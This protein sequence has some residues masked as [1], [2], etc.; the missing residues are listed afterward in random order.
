[1]SF[2]EW[3]GVKKAKPNYGEAE[4][5]YKRMM[6]MSDIDKMRESRMQDW[7]GI[8][9]RAFG[10]I[11]RDV[12]QKWGG[13]GANLMGVE[14]SMPGQWQT[15]A[16]SRWMQDVGNPMARNIEQEWLGATMQQKQGAEMA[17]QQLEEQARA[18]AQ[19]KTG[20]GLGLLGGLAGG[21]GGFLLGGPAGAVAGAGLG[22][23]LGGGSARD[24][25]Q[26][27]NMQNW[28]DPRRNPYLNQSNPI[29]YPQDSMGG[30]QPWNYS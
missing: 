15:Q 26:N 2:W 20:A 22:S 4:S 17:R 23:K 7:R 3:L 11:S 6:D 27:R 1:M 14:S 5:V 8:Q 30:G 29:Y 9:Q 18:E 12:G 28:W 13:T 24:Y 19:A 10:D 16:S 25:V 21:V